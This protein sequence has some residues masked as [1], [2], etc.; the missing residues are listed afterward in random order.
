MTGWIPDALIPIDAPHGLGGFPVDIAPLDTTAIHSKGA[1]SQNQGFW[2]DISLP[3]DQ[4]N[5]PAEMYYGKVKVLQKGN[6]IQEIPLE[7]TLLPHYLPDE[8]H[9]TIWVFSGD[10]YPYFPGLAKKQI[11]DMIKFEGHRHRVDMVGGFAANQ[12]PLIIK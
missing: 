11:D 5:F 2:I 3:R 1:S 7:V 4:K 9:Q 10:V 6:L 8:N 12:S